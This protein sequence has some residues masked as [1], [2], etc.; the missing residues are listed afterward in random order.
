MALQSGRVGVAP[1][2]VDVYGRV[3]GTAS[4]METRVNEDGKPQ[5]REKGTEE[6]QNFKGGVAEVVLDEDYDTALTILIT[7]TATPITSENVKLRV[8]SDADKTTYTDVEF[9]KLSNYELIA[10]VKYKTFSKNIY[11]TTVG[12]SINV[13][14]TQAY[15]ISSSS[16]D[17]NKGYFVT[18]ANNKA[19]TLNHSA[20][21][22]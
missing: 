8:F 11:W 20:Y 5:W 13:S 17:S 15:C 18:R 9:N 2:Q 22:G 14:Y 19:P 12:Q 10:V 7:D 16:Y 6:W 3:T 4:N 1:D 21:R